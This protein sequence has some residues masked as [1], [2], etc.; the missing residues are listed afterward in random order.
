[1][2][3][4]L[5]ILFAFCL[6]LSINAQRDLELTFKKYQNN[7][8]ATSI[9]FD[10]KIMSYVDNKDKD[11]KTKINKVEVLFFGP[12]SDLTQ[13]DIN[14]LDRAIE[15]DNYELLI[16]AKT[17]EGKAKMYGLSEGDDVL[18]VLY[19]QV[20]SDQANIYFM[21]KGDIHF[22][23][24]AEMGLNFEGS[25]VFKMLEQKAKEIEDKVDE[26]IEEKK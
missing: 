25:D 5:T 10:E 2:K 1:M 14:N 24:L 19:A 17:K 8:D 21:L 23:E 20:Q 7:T 12:D 18:K 22:E 3:N 15:A 6:T 13:S 16:N 26:E 11:F 9:S 4:T